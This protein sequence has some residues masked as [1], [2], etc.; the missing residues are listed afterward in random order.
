MTCL[1]GPDLACYV[2]GALDPDEREGLELHLATC[3]TCRTELAHL[4]VL[5]GMLSRIS[6]RD[7]SGGLPEP[8]ADVLAGLVARARGHRRSRRRLLSAAAA[9]LLVAGGVS[10]GVALSGPSSHA[11]TVT[12]SA[13]TVHAQVRL[14]STSAGSRITLRLS[15]VPT[16]VECRMV[17]VSK[18]GTARDAGTWYASYGG[19]ARVRE[20]AAVSLAQLA[21]LR[22]ETTAGRP[23]V[24][25]PVG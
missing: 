20:T 13:G 16:G 25:V 12:A 22:I 3:V 9:V 17:A 23:L 5:P 1:H 18:D 4:S 2:L 7:A 6:A 14:E 10:A 8:E 11:E 24:T 15:G 19:N 21:Q